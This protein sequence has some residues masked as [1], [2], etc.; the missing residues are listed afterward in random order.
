MLVEIQHGSVE[1][2]QQ[3]QKYELY[4]PEEEVGSNVLFSTSMSVLSTETGR[5]SPG[6][7]VEVLQIICDLVFLTGD[8][9]G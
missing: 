5:S 2:P 1:N 6:S 9:R 8:A 3:K 7:Q 4:K